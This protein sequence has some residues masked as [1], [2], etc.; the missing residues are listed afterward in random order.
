MTLKRE[1]DQWFWVGYGAKAVA[2][3]T[4][5]ATRARQEGRPDIAIKWDYEVRRCTADPKQCLKVKLPQA[6]I[7]R[8]IDRP[9][10]FDGPPWWKDL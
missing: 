6:F 7:D 8:F 1:R 9:T 3:A 5:C 2:M 4:D 10:R